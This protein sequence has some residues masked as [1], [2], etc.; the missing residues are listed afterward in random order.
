LIPARVIGN[1]ADTT[2]QVIYVN[3]GQRDGVK[4]DMGVIT[5]DGIVG[6]VA[7]VYGET[8]QIQLLTDKYSGAGAMLAGSRVQSPVGGT[9]EPLL[10]MKYVPSDDEVNVGDQVVTNGMDRIF[11]KDLP[12]GTV[13]EVKPGTPFKL[14]RVKPAAKLERLEEV[15]ILAGLEPINM[16]KESESVGDAVK[17]VSPTEKTPAAKPAN[18]KTAPK[19]D[20][21]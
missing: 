18:E 14:V 6:K 3:R 2:S 9:G 10:S 8:S 13:T 21:P 16:K 11:P 5:P 1:S 17:D 15:I 20:R 7:D 4:R 19:A 12:V